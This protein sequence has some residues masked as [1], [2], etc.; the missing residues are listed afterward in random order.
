MN[1]EELA[2]ALRSI[3]DRIDRS[4]MPSRSAVSHEVEKVLAAIGDPGVAAGPTKVVVCES[5]SED[6]ARAAAKQC[7]A[8]AIGQDPFGNFGLE[9]PATAVEKC[10]STVPGD[11]TP[12][13]RQIGV[14]D[15]WDA[16]GDGDSEYSFEMLQL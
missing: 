6:E 14:F 13:E 12:Q 16:I 3:A 10:M 1:P 15:S 5:W 2:L 11:G 9:V 4:E 8:V 7:G